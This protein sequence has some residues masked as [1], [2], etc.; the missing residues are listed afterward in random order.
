MIGSPLVA[1]PGREKN[2]IP[3]ESRM[4]IFPFSMSWFSRRGEKNPTNCGFATRGRI[5]FLY[6]SADG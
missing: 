4:V 2:K 1:K 5:F 6:S 3:H